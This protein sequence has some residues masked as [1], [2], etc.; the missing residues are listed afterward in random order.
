MDIGALRHAVT[1]QNP[2]P[3]VKD[4]DG[5]YTTAWADL[6]TQWWASIQPATVRSLERAVA[7]TVV[8]AATHLV[9]MRYLPGVTTAT[10]ILFGTRVLNVTGVQNQDERNI[11][12]VLVCEEAVQ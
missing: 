11:E 4:A 1:V 10:R 9:R 6:A 2:L 5:G 7:G 3:P 12:L 8:S